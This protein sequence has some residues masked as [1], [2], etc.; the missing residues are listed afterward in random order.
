M[1]CGFVKLSNRGTIRMKDNTNLVLLL[2]IGV[3]GLAL[4]LAGGTVLSLPPMPPTLWHV[5]VVFVAADSES[6]DELPFLRPL[7]PPPVP[8]PLL[9]L[10][11]I[12]F[13]VN[14][15]EDVQALDPLLL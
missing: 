10:P 5:V 7:T 15:G 2:K 6:V 12:P 9:L 4:S 3:A 1:N 8:P 14:E 13:D 11:L